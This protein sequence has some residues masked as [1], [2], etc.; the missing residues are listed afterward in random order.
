MNITVTQ[1]LV[2]VIV[3]A[4]NKI[5]PEHT[6]NKEDITS[7]TLDNCAIRVNNFLV[8]WETVKLA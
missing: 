5:Y 6:I 2:D 8:S 7:M 4:F 3:A 1:S